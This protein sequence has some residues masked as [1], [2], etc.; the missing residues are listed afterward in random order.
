MEQ[1]KTP[2]PPLFF[3]AFVGIFMGVK[4]FSIFR[5]C[6]HPSEEGG[7]GGGGGGGGEGVDLRGHW[8]SSSRGMV[9]SLPSGVT[10]RGCQQ[11]ILFLCEKPVFV[12]QLVS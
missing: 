4:R 9:E 2:F 10:N 7:G 5:K 11:G 12:V 8:A 6:T 1:D 3:D